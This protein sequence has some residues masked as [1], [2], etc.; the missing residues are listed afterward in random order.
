VRRGAR[1]KKAAGVQQTRVNIMGDGGAR[2]AEKREKVHFG[3]NVRGVGWRLRRR[4]EETELNAA[5]KKIVQSQGWLNR[6]GKPYS[7]VRDWGKDSA[8]TGTGH[9]R[10]AV[11][12]NARI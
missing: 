2:G 12:R 1:G 4:H 11:S 3:P 10:P 7:E 9:P 8:Q 5:Q 6:A